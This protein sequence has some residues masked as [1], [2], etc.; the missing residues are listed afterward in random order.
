MDTPATDRPT[1]VQIANMIMAYTGQPGVEPKYRDRLKQCGNLPTVSGSCY[2]LPRRRWHQELTRR[3][4][5]QYRRPERQLERPKRQPRRPDRQQSVQP[6][7]NH[8]RPKKKTKLSSLS[9]R[10]RQRKKLKSSLQL[11]DGRAQI[12]E[13]E[14]ALAEARAANSADDLVEAGAGNRGGNRGNEQGNKLTGEGD[15]IE[16]ED[17][18]TE[19]QQLGRKDIVAANIVPYS[20]RST[21]PYQFGIASGTR[22]G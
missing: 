5:K 22:D 20:Q 6:V 14:A 7:I 4:Q 17:A 13:L 21:E 8:P 19:D 2:Q 9:L 18:G 16:E 3:S 11:P 10:I 1:L 15:Q 12:I